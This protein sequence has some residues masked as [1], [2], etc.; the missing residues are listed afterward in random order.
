[1][2]CGALRQASSEGAF[3]NRLSISA[4]ALVVCAG[5]SAFAASERASFILTN[6]ERESG[7]IAGYGPR[8]ENL[9]NGSLTLA[10]ERRDMTFPLEEVAV[11]DFTG[12]EP[13][14]AELARLGADQAL[15]MR[16]GRIQPG[17]FVNIIDGDTV[18]WDTGSSRPQRFAIRDISRVYLNPERARWVFNDRGGRYLGGR[19]SAGREDRGRDYGGRDSSGRDAGGRDSSGRTSGGA[20]S[21]QASG[22]Q[23]QVQVR[24]EANQ[25]WTD[26]GITVNTG[27]RVVFNA[28]GQIAFGKGSGQT[29]GPDGNPSE[30][31]ASYPD[32]TVPVG[33]LI[34]RV[35]NS[36]PFGI[37]MQKQ[38]LPMPASGRLMLGVN[39]NELADNS[40]FYTVTVTRP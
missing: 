25:A 4:A 24:V 13:T 2:M 15:V 18:L 28:S 40:G 11:I 22:R 33:A 8:S 1:M 7:T 6:G 34:G 38:P 31:R 29:S 26:T 9:I 17:R 12:G 5:V 14:S 19:D 10:T 23:V 32:P 16:N 39:D 27:D 37:G 30:R 3:M 21:G 35:G 36:A 20:T